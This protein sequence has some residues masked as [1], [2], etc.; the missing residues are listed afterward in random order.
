M[1]D[2]L[3]RQL[4]ESRF[5]AFADARGRK[6]AWEN[7]ALDPEP[8]QYFEAFVLPGTTTSSDLAGAHRAY[9]GVVQFNVVAPK[10]GGLADA[11]EVAQAIVDLFPLNLELTSGAFKVKQVSPATI[12]RAIPDATRV[13]VPVSFRYRADT[14]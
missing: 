2:Q 5:Q 9:V 7:E 6:V 1:S 4:Y 10:G 12:A 3:I 13:R 8:E 14:I 11:L